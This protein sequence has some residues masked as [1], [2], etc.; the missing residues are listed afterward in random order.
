M[1]H[2]RSCLEMWWM[3]QCLRLLHSSHKLTISTIKI[4]KRPGLFTAL[5]RSN[6]KLHCTR[7]YIHLNLFFSFILRAIAVL[8]KDAILFSHEHVECTKQPSLVSE[9]IPFASFKT[10]KNLTDPKLLKKY[11]W[12]ISAQLV[13]QKDF[14]NH[15]FS[16]LCQLVFHCLVKQVIPFPFFTALVQPEVTLPDTSNKQQCLFP[17][18]W[19]TLSCLHTLKWDL[20]QYS[21]IKKM[22]HFTFKS[23]NWAKPV[24]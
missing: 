1:I 3:E 6:R 21:N 18:K 24:S 23:L 13:T 9:S 22:T 7:N 4:E 14:K 19:V 2:L 8:V 11:N 15:C 16:T 12:I 5:S 10:F 17:Y 20:R